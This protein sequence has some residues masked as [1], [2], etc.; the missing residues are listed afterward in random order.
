MC[1]LAQ[2]FVTLSFTSE[3]IFGSIDSSK[4]L[5][6]M[7]VRLTDLEL[8]LLARHGTLNELTHDFETRSRFAC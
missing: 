1:V 2:E 6:L 4:N 8:K 3:R 5:Y 7:E